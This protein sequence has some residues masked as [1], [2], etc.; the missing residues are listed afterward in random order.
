M[1]TFSRPVV[2]ALSACLATAVP[3]EGSAREKPAAGE[4]RRNFVHPDEIDGFAVGGR[5]FKMAR[6]AIP[7]SCFRGSLIWRGPGAE[8]APLRPG[9]DYPAELDDPAAPLPAPPQ[10]GTDRTTLRSQS[11]HFDPNGPADVTFHWEP[12]E[13]P[14]AAALGASAASGR[15]SGGTVRGWISRY[16]VCV[17]HEDA[18]CGAADLADSLIYD[19]GC[20]TELEISRSRPRAPMHP[21]GVQATSGLPHSVKLT[22]GG[23][24]ES[25]YQGQVLRWQVR[26]CN[27]AACGQWSAAKEL[28][29]PLPAPI[30]LAPGTPGPDPT[31]PL[32]DGTL[33]LTG[34]TAAEFTWIPV[35]GAETYLVCV[36]KDHRAC[37]ET[38]TQGVQGVWTACN[39]NSTTG[40][41]R[42]AAKL[43]P[44][45]HALND[46]K[47]FGHSGTRVRWAVAACAR[48]NSSVNDHPSRCTYGI[49][50]Y[51]PGLVLSYH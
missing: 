41:C 27:N 45:S 4:E 32:G 24:P 47:D 35:V 2:L 23:A 1:Q 18:T 5:L 16:E 26:A 28:D 10:T 12:S 15:F 13:V 30:H 40:I 3:V 29:W 44:R 7:A 14:L 31:L 34:S 22:S 43:S 36:W 51:D 46:L 39:D 42:S 8:A 11:T 19:A 48:N 38:R 6:L 21:A 37:G 33:D 9:I 50:F 17:R 49:E 25:I 20:A